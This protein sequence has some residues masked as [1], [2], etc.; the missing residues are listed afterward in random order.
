MAR[1]RRAT[2][3]D[4]ELVLKFR[5]ARVPPSVICDLVGLSSEQVTSLIREGLRPAKGKHPAKRPINT[6]LIEARAEQVTLA[7]EWA[8]SLAGAARRTA[9]ERAETAYAAAKIERL[10]VAAWAQLI[11]SEVELAA[12][13]DRVVQLATM[14]P[15]RELL[16]ALRTLARTRD[17]AADVRAPIE[18]YRRTLDETGDG[19]DAA[20]PEIDPTIYRDLLDL[21]DDA[22]EHFA[23][24]GV[25][26]PKQLELPSG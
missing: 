17:L 16:L 11:D 15:G 12:R 2:L 20:I 23:L 8:E 19:D 24:T 10:L 25:L 26:E 3:E 13:E 4:Y 9:V 6:V 1:A 21:G 18:V 7:R 5:R 22:L 14:L